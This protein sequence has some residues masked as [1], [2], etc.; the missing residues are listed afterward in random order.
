MVKI[1]RDF[2]K[3]NNIIA[4]VCSAGSLKAEWLAS[5]FVPFVSGDI[6]RRTN[7]NATLK[8][9]KNIVVI[10]VPYEKSEFENLSSLGTND[11]YHARVKFF[12]RALVNELKNELQSQKNFKYKILIDSPG[13]DERALAYH[14]GLGFFGRNGLIISSEFGS[15]FNIG[16]LFTDIGNE[17]E[18][19]RTV[20]LSNPPDSLC[21][22]CNLCINACPT[23]ALSENG[24]QAQKCI[25]YL[26]Q[27]DELSPEEEKLLSN[28]RQ[29]YG[30]DICA[31]V[32]P[33]NALT[34]KHTKVKAILVNPQEW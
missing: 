18:D 2:A 12:L 22:D 34:T 24:F 33:F 31:D 21:T 15:R 16:C 27:K 29:L 5:P 3:K 30:C 20:H 9:A 7:P 8:G 26:T 19:K 11:D 10:G 14:A 1:V 32:C 17:G 6:E 23:N 4:G 25:S 28:S 13:P